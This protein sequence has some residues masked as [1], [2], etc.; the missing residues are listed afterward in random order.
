[1]RYFFLIAVL[2]SAL[3]SPSVHAQASALPVVSVESPSEIV[4][5]YRP[6]SITTTIS[7]PYDYD[8]SYDMVIEIFYDGGTDNSTYPS[9]YDG[10]IY[11]MMGNQTS[12]KLFIRG[13]IPAGKS[14]VYIIETASGIWTGDYRLISVYDQSGNVFESRRITL[15]K[16]TENPYGIIEVQG[17]NG[18]NTINPGEFVLLSYTLFAPETG[19]FIVDS[20]SSTHCSFEALSGGSVS[21]PNSTYAKFSFYTRVSENSKLGAC[22]ITGSFHLFRFPGVSYPMELKFNIRKEHFLPI[23]TR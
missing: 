15:T 16:G 12:I 6:Y 3:F 19:Q 4:Y 22:K 18:D 20:L 14:H 23:I 17:L 10:E 21:K 1:M 2:L 7:N 8:L 5:G 11:N 9:R 13:M